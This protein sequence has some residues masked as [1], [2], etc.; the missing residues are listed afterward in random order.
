MGGS[1]VVDLMLIGSP[2]LGF[3]NCSMFFSALLYVLSSFAIILMAK[4]ELVA[5]LCFTSWRLMIVMWLF[6]TMPRLCLQFVIVIF[7][8]HTC[9]HL[10]FSNLKF[11]TLQF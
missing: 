5:L 3:C 10:L 9:I 2:L 1:V 7:P 8:D 4:R 6:L 11:C